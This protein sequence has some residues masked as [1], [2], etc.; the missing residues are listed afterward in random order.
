M[1]LPNIGS[2]D[3]LVVLLDAH[4]IVRDG[5]ESLIERA[6]DLSV[7]GS[8][9]TVSDLSKCLHL[10]QV[11][12]VVM[13]LIFDGN[14]G[15]RSIADLAAAHPGTRFL[16]L[17]QL[18]EA[19]YAERVLHAGGSGYVMKHVSATVLLDAVRRV[20][21]G[22]V[23]VSSTAASHLLA[24]FSKHSFNGED[25]V[26]ERLTDRELHVLGLVGQG[27]ATAVIASQMG[28]SKKTVGTFKERIKTKLS[29]TSSLQLSQAAMQRLGRFQ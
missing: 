3:L 13:G 4:G 22:E 29:L 25:D 19:V 24:N 26:F 23:V 20:A 10:I 8:V 9:A 7:V 5:L 14:D 2:V 17:S 16:V 15:L 6:D 1:D 27:H 18:P 11:D 12:V 28:I 21:A